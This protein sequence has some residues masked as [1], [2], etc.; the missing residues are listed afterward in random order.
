M[1]SRLESNSY[2]WLTTG[3][4]VFPVMLDAIASARRTIRFEFYIYVNDVIGR[5]FRDALIAARKRGVRVQV[6][7]DSLGSLTLPGNYWHSLV[8]AGGEARWFNPLL[9]RRFGYRDHR[10]MLVCDEEI[11]FVGGFNI[12]AVYQG[13][14]IKS[15]WR[16]LGLKCTG[17]MAQE[18]ATAFDEMFDRADFK[19]KRLSRIRGEP[20]ARHVEG[21]DCQLLLTGPGRG[22]N[23]FSRALHQDLAHARDVKIIAAYFLPTWRLR[24]DL[25]LVVQ[26]GGRV[27]LL[28]PGKSDVFLSQLAG[29]SLYRRLF[30]AGVEI[31]EYQP[32]ILHAK[33]ILIDDVVY[34]GSSNLDTRSLRINYELMLRIANHQAVSQAAEIFADCARLSQKIE[35]ETWRRAR[36]WWQGFKERLAYFLLIRIDPLIVRW[37]RAR[38]PN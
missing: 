19:H 17:H 11:V 32:Q 23:P 18:L 2:Q 37:S 1:A 14:G 9:L 3:D 33:L 35:P 5:Q 16:D 34:A 26:G 8:S 28:L 20:I 7:I 29:R 25:A 4:E 24:R 12:S 15:G 27:Q 21:E 6:L 31:H 36:T 10:K 30:K 13:D 22:W 38:R